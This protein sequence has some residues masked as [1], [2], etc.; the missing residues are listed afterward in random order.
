MDHNL[1]LYI[2]KVIVL[3]NA[4]LMGWEIH[5]IS[6]NSYELRKKISEQK[7]FDLENFINTITTDPININNI[8]NNH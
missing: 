8:F 7:T 5:K 6:N 3:Y 2:F 1:V 4:Y